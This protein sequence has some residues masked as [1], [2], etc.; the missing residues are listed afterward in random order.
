MQVCWALLSVVFHLPQSKA[1]L[2][3][4]ELVALA[5]CVCALPF[6]GV[7]VLW[8]WRGAGG[9]WSLS[10]RGSWAQRW[11]GGA[12]APESKG[13]VTSLS[14][15][16]LPKLRGYSQGKGDLHQQSKDERWFFASSFPPVWRVWAWC[17]KVIW[18]TCTFLQYL[19]ACWIS[20]Y[21]CYSRQ[22]PKPEYN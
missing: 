13:L 18:L 16:A 3:K 21:S 6:R 5:P 7:T 17:W 15:T 9:V 20:L 14:G 4:F 11:A 22:K 12:T 8:V 2:L 19:S 1:E 10:R